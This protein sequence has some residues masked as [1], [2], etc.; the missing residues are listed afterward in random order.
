MSK[1]QSQSQNAAENNP[2]LTTSETPSL[3]E[4]L[5]SP[6]WLVQKFSDLR[7]SCVDAMCTSENGCFSATE[8][9]AAFFLMS[10]KWNLDCKT[11]ATKR[12]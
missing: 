4:R 12:E 10:I 8:D 11:T 9:G 5:P 2:V 6:C 7:L 3:T 1:S